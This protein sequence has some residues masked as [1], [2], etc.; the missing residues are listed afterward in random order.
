M[1]TLI[2]TLTLL[3][4]TCFGAPQPTT[5][6]NAWTT[7][8]SVLPVFGDNNLSVSNRIAGPGG[9]TNWNF[10]GIGPNTVARLTDVT[11]SGNG[12]FVKK[13]NGPSDGQIATNAN[14]A[15]HFTFDTF[16]DNNGVISYDLAGVFHA[17]ISIF[18]SDVAVQ[19]NQTNT[20][21]MDIADDL[22]TYSSILALGGIG[23]FAESAFHSAVEV[24][25]M[26][27]GKLASYIQIGGKVYLTNSVYSDSDIA[28]LQAANGTAPGFS[29]E[30]LFNNGGHVSNLVATPSFPNGGLLGTAFR[31]SFFYHTNF[32]NAAE[33][34][35]NQNSDGSIVAHWTRVNA[36]GIL[37][38]ST[39]TDFW[40]TNWSAP[41]T[42]LTNIWFPSVVKMSD[43]WYLM[44]RTNY[45][46]AG[47]SNVFLFSSSDGVSW[48]IANSGNAVFT[49][50]TGFYAQPLNPAFTVSTNGIAY[51]AL[52][53]YTNSSPTKTSMF[54]STNT[55]SKKDSGTL[56]FTAPTTPT[57][58]GPFTLQADG[59]YLNPYLVY[60]SNNNAVLLFASE[61]QSPR[62]V[63]AGVSVAK[64]NTG[65]PSAGASW[66][67]ATNSWELRPATNNL[68]GATDPVFL[69]GITN[70]A[71]TAA[72][73][74]LFAQSTGV[75]WFANCALPDFY[76]NAFQTNITR[77]NGSL[78]VDNGDVV[79]RGLG[80]LYATAP[81]FYTGGDVGQMQIIAQNSSQQG[82]FKL[83]GKNSST[84]ETWQ[85]ASR[86][87]L[88]TPNNR[89]SIFDPNLNEA[90]TLLN[91]GQVGI[92]MK[93]PS[94]LLQASNSTAK[95]T[96]LLESL[97]TNNFLE[98]RYGTART[99]AFIVNSNWIGFQTNISFPSP[100]PG[101]VLHAFSN[102]D[103]YIIT[104]TKTN[105]FAVG[106]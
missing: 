88:D 14:L 95:T 20:G 69:F 8:R 89:L 21:T 7:N 49:K 9:G 68:Y 51:F 40:M 30:V 82:I 57:F 76:Q 16:N 93:N 18:N 90:M 50:D 41:I 19:G 37:Y 47:S 23:A 39:N 34:S 1:R 85:F 52:E 10:Y 72:A 79:I 62:G 43:A 22:T 3:A 77:I 12:L 29:G 84:L 24:S 15:T 61:F 80:S 105:L 32:T 45:N 102:Y 25:L 78:Q 86:G 28:A 4:V 97:A 104:P 67:V 91:G 70:K 96:L 99:P 73:F 31:E 103:E 46:I 71:F 63:F 58:A 94:A 100:I 66:T 17:G 27:A 64:Y 26:T 74:T 11:N 54:V 65:D 98:I 55:W 33:I 60:E 92:M 83:T 101:M 56:T 2:F 44:G 36:Q 106:Q 42:V 13:F 59:F 81:I 87:S 5:Y 38:R 48:S 75:Q 35:L 6:L 53:C